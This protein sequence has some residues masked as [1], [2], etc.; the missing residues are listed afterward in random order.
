MSFTYLDGKLH[1]FVKTILNRLK[2]MLGPEGAKNFFDQIMQLWVNPEVSR[3]KQE[4]TWPDCFL[5][6]KC[7]ITFPK[8]KSPIVKFNDEANLVARIKIAPGT[9][10]QKGQPVYVHEVQYIDSVMAPKYHKKPV[11][12]VYFVRDGGNNFQ[13]FFDFSPNWPEGQLKKP[14]NEVSVC[15]G[16]AEFMQ[17]KLVE[18]AV[19]VQESFQKQLY[20][21]GLWTA[22]ALLPYP[23]SKIVLQLEKDDIDGAKSTLVNHCTPEFL[24][25]LSAKWWNIKEFELRRTLIEAA[26]N[27]H[28]EG[29]YVL[30]IPALLPQIEGIISDWTYNQKPEDLPVRIGSKTKKFR[31]TLLEKPKPF[32]YNR[33]VNSSI[34]FVLE[35]PVLKSFKNWID[36]IEKAFPNRHEVEHGKYDP[37]LFTEQ[38]SIKLILLIDTLFFIISEQST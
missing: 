18:E 24:E 21:I 19:R 14:T 26:I 27:A 38:N 13:I 35:G 2:N 30:S 20:K 37:S 33:V 36:N 3:R 17:K 8:G 6:N 12:F 10:F 11:A 16:I 5:I 7:L 9:S 1:I 22:P 25:K 15:A 31:D 4:G 32:L 28:K 23:L 29:K 34:N